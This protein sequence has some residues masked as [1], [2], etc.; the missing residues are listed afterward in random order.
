MALFIW[1]KYLTAMS[2]GVISSASVH[3]VCS[4]MELSA[5][6][7]GRS[8]LKKHVLVVGLSIF[9]KLFPSPHKV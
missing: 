5:E 9:G 8:S 2:M 7:T 6:C 4:S 3:L 1:F